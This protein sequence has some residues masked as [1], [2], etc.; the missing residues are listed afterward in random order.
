MRRLFLGTSACLIAGACHDGG[1]GNPSMTGFTVMTATF[2]GFTTSDLPTSGAPQ[3]VDTET[4]TGTATGGGTA[5][6][7]ATTM[8]VG[9]TITAATDMTGMTGQTGMSGMT[10]MSDAGDTG[11]QGTTATPSSCGDGA[12]DPGEE[13][14]NGGENGPDQ[15]CYA[16]CTLNRCGDGVSEGPEDCDLGPQNGQDSGCSLDCKVLPSACGMQKVAA[17]VTIKPVDIVVLIDNS[18]SMAAEI[19]G[20][21]SNINKNFADIL[22]ASGLD[23]RVIMVSAFGK[24]AAYKVCIE[25]PLGGIPPGG[26]V[27]PPPVPIN[28]PGIFY[29]YST[30][31][32]SVNAA[33]RALSTF[34][35]LE[36]DMYGFAP[37]GWQAWLRADALKVFLV[38]TDDQMAC[39]YG[40]KTYDDSNNAAD[41]IAAAKALDVAMLA[42][43]PLH[44][45]TAEA[46]NY[47][48]YSIVGM[49][50][51][52]P[53]EDP[54]VATDPL[55]AAKC[56]SAVTSGLGY[57]ALS[58]VTGGW[59]FPLCDT[60]KYDQI[61]HGIAQNVVAGAKIACDFV[62]PAAPEGKIL[63]EQSVVVHVTPEG[64]MNPVVYNQVAGPGMCAPMAFYV[65]AGEVIL[66]P[67]ACAALQNDKDVQIEVEFTCEP[68]IP[69]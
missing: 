38:I 57:Q 17:Q 31:L 4:G 30:P 26:C 35:G 55:I 13:C 20:V 69:N 8:A 66:C 63:D 11:Q 24:N 58:N 53:P 10:D 7:G 68:L 54:F 18:G 56:V 39:S 42:K 16:D 21:E 50:F 60:T 36:P 3:D 45:G 62:I 34:D 59:R 46:R 51:N 40:E 49:S 44:F 28:N 23:Y 33:C 1:G 64:Q 22:A 25:A 5:S 29:H 14:D 9:A 41:A 27:E 52:V 61:F 32:S 12:L 65:Q 19:A 67:E 48:W 37:L 6:E 43:S 2:P 15:A 47:L